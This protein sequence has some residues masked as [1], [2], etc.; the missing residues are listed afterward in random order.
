MR[1][2]LKNKIS[3][4]QQ[5][6]CLATLCGLPLTSLAAAEARPAPAAGA[7]IEVNRLPF[8]IADEKR[9]SDEDLSEKR[10]G[11]YVTGIPEFSSD[12][13]NGFGYGAEG[14]I[15]FNGKK[16]DALFNYA[17]YKHRLDIVLFNTT[18]NQR[19]IA[20]KYDSPY[21]FGSLWRMRTTAAYE[22]NPNLV[23]F[24][25][26]ERSLQG[27]SYY[28][29]G[30]TSQTLVQ[31]ASYSDYVSGLGSANQY[32]NGYRKEEGILNLSFE[33][34]VLQSKVRL[35]GG[36]EFARVGISSL[37][38]TS[39]IGN[40]SAAGTIS[41]VGVANI[42]MAQVGV[43][44]DT[45]DLEP[46][47]NRGIFAELTNEYS[48]RALG[49]AYDFNKTFLHLRWYYPILPN[50]FGKMI[51]A[52]RFGMG[53]TAGDAPF[54]EYQDQ[55][56]SEGSIEGLGGAHTLR[57]YKQGRFL[58]RVMN[59]ANIELRIRFAQTDIFKQHFAF[60]IVPFLDVG[61]VWD[62]FARLN[63]SENYRFSTGAG[64]RIAWNVNTIMRFD[65]A[66]S[67]EDQQF[68]FNFGHAF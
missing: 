42:S 43:V 30:D 62:S 46:D 66:Y 19:E 51:L 25:T 38:A 3:R 64:L 36:Y 17:P 28:P 63:H 49:S 41:G 12:P 59:F 8:E 55:W 24:G 14:S 47:P 34:S 10:E 50:T 32:Y 68:F 18:K 37:Q 45:R 22:D 26:T 2:L 9:L 6:L 16:N 1:I 39:L 31:N 58:A 15:F 56:S 5:A 61:G 13:L 35:V 67:P 53:Y 23:Y 54:F 29:G 65:Y 40:D 11:M 4:L 48:N 21:I 44:Y 20:L 7:N 27:L 33:R 57:G 60:S 52:T